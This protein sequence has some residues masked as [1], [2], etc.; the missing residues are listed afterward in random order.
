M[1]KLLLTKAQL[2]ELRA[3]LSLLG[4]RDTDLPETPSVNSGDY[5]AIVQDNVNKKV[6]IS[7]LLGPDVISE[8]IEHTYY[9]KSA[10]EL[11]V[12]NGFE[13][14]EEEWLASLSVIAARHTDG[15]LYWQKSGKWLLDD[16]GEMI[17]AEGISGTNGTNGRDGTDGTNGRDGVDGATDLKMIYSSKDNPGSPID[18]PGDWSN[19]ASTS[20]KFMALSVKSANQWGPWTVLRFRGEDGTA[21][22]NAVTGFKSIVFKR[23]NS[24]ISGTRPSGGTF[25]SP[26]PPEGGW[27]DGAPSGQEILWMSSRW[28]YSDD[29]LTAETKWSYPSQTTD[30]E[31]VDFEFSAVISPGN[32]TDNPGNWHNMDE[33]DENDIWMA[34]RRKKNGEWETGGSTKGWAIVKVKGED[35]APGRD[36]TSVT[37]KDYVSSE[38]DLEEITDPDIGDVY[39]VSTTGDAWVW[40]GTEWINMGSIIGPAGQSNYIHV[41][42]SDDGGVT[43]TDNYGLTPGT[44]FGYCI[45]TTGVRPFNANAYSWSRHTGEDGTSFE[46]I[47]K[48]TEDDTAP[49]IPSSP[50]SALDPTWEA[51][52][53]DDFVPTGWY[54]DPVGINEQYQYCWMCYR[55]K[56]DGKWGQWIGNSQN[57]AVLWAKWGK[58]GLDGAS[59]N[60]A[61]KSLVF[62]RSASQPT[63]PTG[64]SYEYPIPSG[65]EDGI[66]SGTDYVWMST[67]IFSSDGESPQQA[68]WTTPKNLTD[69]RYVDYIFSSEDT[70]SAPTKSDPTIP[71]TSGDWYEYDGCNERTQW[72]AL[73]AVD[74][75]AYATGSSWAVMKIKGEDGQDG[76]SVSLKGTYATLAALEYDTEQSIIE[77]EEGDAYTVG[78]DSAGDYYL[79]VWDGDSWVGAGKFN[80]SNAYVHIKY[81]NDGGTT[82]TANGG[83][84]PGSYIGICHDNN[85]TDPSVVSAYTWSYWEGQDGF[86][87]EW[88]Y[89]RSNSSN[90]PSVPSAPTS[91]SDSGWSTYQQDDYVP[92][93]WSDNPQT[94]TSSYRYGWKC[95][96][97][98]TDGTW[99][100][101]KG[102][103]SDNSKAAFEAYLSA[104]GSSGSS[105]Y[106]TASIDL[107]YRAP[108]SPTP[109][110]PANNV[111]F[112]FSSN[113]ITNGST[114][115]WTRTHQASNSNGDPEWVTSVQ[116]A[117]RNA[118]VTISSSDWSTP[119][120]NTQDGV[121]GEKGDSPASVYRGEWV[122]TN[123]Y[124]GNSGRRDIVK[125][126]GNGTYYIAKSNAGDAFVNSTIPPNS[127]LWE[128]F[129]ANY[130]NIA[131]GLIFAQEEYVV[132]LGVNRLK[133][134][135]ND[136]VVA[137]MMPAN[138]SYNGDNILWAGSATASS[139]PFKVDKTGKLTA[140]GA[141]ITG[142]ITATSGSFTGT[143]NASSGEIG[144]YTIDQDGIRYQD[145]STGYWADFFKD[146]I[147]LSKSDSQG[148][149][150]FVLSTSRS[151][152]PLITLSE[153]GRGKPALHIA[154]GYITGFGLGIRHGGSSNMTLDATDN[155]VIFNNSSTKTITLSP[156]DYLDGHIVAIIHTSSSTLN[157]TSSKPIVRILSS[158][159]SEVYTADSGRPEVML[160]IYSASTQK[161]Y[162]SYLKSS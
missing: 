34:I 5:V 94:L 112:T 38:S 161:W 108:A 57:K 56:K 82:F 140:T 70:P 144:P 128:A 126:A 127:S 36:G 99:G 9:G 50:S 109:T 71:L 15:K 91:P 74:N 68:T 2:E 64:G 149:S 131:T 72:M 137:G 77:P 100:P 1:N 138:P 145:A 11:A 22:L 116:V 37:I 32:P 115:P 20:S 75:G 106:N 46:Y 159:T 35:G 79:Y 121:P 143:I 102:N 113:S 114:S 83:E 105:G 117:S 153:H 150:S 136:T 41:A 16:R 3:Q 111:T 85:A 54:D 89:S 26:V 69:E 33:A 118:T 146:Q 124:Y 134:L 21:G 81:S 110:K 133:V 65:W 66:P 8:L 45:E 142:A 12:E 62:K 156:Y 155:V 120:I 92:S 148:Q 27:T 18:A 14:T 129:G 53:V 25:L 151:I 73:R 119:V 42:F 122:A 141:D 76:R 157:V 97:K 80:G 31:D 60:T 162:L 90:P 67:R 132:N 160:A 95:Y 63:T 59:P 30:T 58:D 93:G 44:Y 48:A 88:I 28:F 7:E 139:A 104:D 98:K 123:A 86:G 6:K 61:F 23:T 10:Y 158:G 103:A 13:G 4:V 130:A 152:A 78:P 19:V 96:R 47:Y 125:Y 17:L 43:L 101:W 40:N 49:S 87:Y 29:A 39:I 84:T 24:D 135:D 147:S 107:Y 51:Y 52:Q 55:R 154:N